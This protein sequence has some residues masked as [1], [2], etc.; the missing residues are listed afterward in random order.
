[1][2]NR[3]KKTKGIGTTI[4]VCAIFAC[5]LAISYNGY[6]SNSAGA[7]SDLTESAE[8]KIKV[9]DSVTGYSLY[10][11]T[12]ISIPAGDQA[13]NRE[14]PTVRVIDNDSMGFTS[15][16]LPKGRLNLTLR[17][18]G[19]QDLDTHFE[20]EAGEIL[21][22]NILLDPI[23]RP[24]ELRPE[25]IQ[26]QLKPGICLL[27][28][29][30]VDDNGIPLEGVTVKLKGQ[31]ASATT[32]ERGY[33]RIRARVPATAADELVTD[34]LVAKRPGYQSYKI[35]NTLIFEG[36][37]HFLIDMQPGLGETGRNDDHKMVLAKD[38]FNRLDQLALDPVSETAQI[39]NEQRALASIENIKINPQTVYLKS[40]VR[41]GY[42]C[43]CSTCSSVTVMSN[44]TY[45][46]RGLN[47]EWIA[48]WSAN[49]LRAGAV[50][51]RSYGQY[52]MRNPIRSNYDICNTTCCQVNDSDTSTSTTAAADYTSG[53]VVTRDNVTPFRAEYSAE[54]NNGY[55]ADGYAGSP[56]TSWPCISD[57]LCKGKEFF[58]HGRG[59]CQWGTQRWSL[60]GKTWTWIVNHYY[61]N[62]GNPSGLRSATL[63]K[64]VF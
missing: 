29:H 41:L 39:E 47:D 4:R 1:M 48:S 22:A 20:L 7:K 27:H 61:N 63:V 59:M 43:S 45:M 53:Y 30:I 9:R 36:D 54:N 5:L 6:L 8:L 49:S 62:N 28:G 64:G 42:N 56:A 10:S 58:G 3:I 55:C 25:V 14:Q 32:D 46:Y 44:A 24:A 37:T 21:E 38:P 17:A 12:T 23:E 16:Q 19:Y 11:Q 26:A 50:A 52:Y 18:P 15:V 33:F 60:N 2:F 40:S 35:E 31:G 13:A 34:T 51:Y 57:M